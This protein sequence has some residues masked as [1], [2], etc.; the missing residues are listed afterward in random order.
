MRIVTVAENHPNV[1]LVTRDFEGP[2]VDFEMTIQDEVDPHIYLS[3]ALIDQAAE[4]CGYVSQD[5]VLKAQ[6]RCE[7]LE[8]E[9][10]RLE[11]AINATNAL[12]EAL[13]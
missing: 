4:M 2:W 8:K 11:K 3:T 7:E 5:Q 6:R 13:R 12:E 9:I 10:E 1:C